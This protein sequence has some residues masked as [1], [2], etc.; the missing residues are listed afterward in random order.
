MPRMSWV[1]VQFERVVDVESDHLE[2]EGRKDLL[3]RVH[4]AVGKL[5][6]RC[7]ISSSQV[8]FRYVYNKSRINE[9]HFTG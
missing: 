7:I 3:E 4:Q 5:I 8:D 1:F 9:R 6:R 2:I